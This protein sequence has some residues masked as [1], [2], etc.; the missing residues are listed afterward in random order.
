LPSVQVAVMEFTPVIGKVKPWLAV[1]VHEYPAGL[2]VL[3][4]TVCPFVILGKL[5]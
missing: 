4:H 2:V 1:T 3:E 5:K